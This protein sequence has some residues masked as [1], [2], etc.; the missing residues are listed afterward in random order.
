MPDTAALEHGKRV[1][2][3]IDAFILK[4]LQEEALDP[5]PLADRLMLVRRAYFDLLGLPP[6]AEQVDAFLADTSPDAWKNLVN[7]LLDSKHYGERWARHWLDVARYA[8]SGGFES[9]VA[10]PNSWR[11]RDYV[12]R[13]FN[14]DKPYD[15]FVQEQIAGDEIW[16]DNRDLDPKRVYIMS[17]AK[18]R[19]LE[20]RIG[21]GLYGFGSRVAEST[22]DARRWHHETLTDWVD[23]TAS[24]FMGLTIQCARCHD[25][26]FDPISQED[27]YGMQAIFTSSI[28]VEEPIIT[29]TEVI[30]W[31][32]RYPLIVHVHE[33]R[34]AYKRFRER[35]EGR[36]LTEAEHTEETRL[37][38]RIVDRVMKL[39][40]RNISRP[41][42]PHDPLM[43]IP[44]ATVLGH[45]RREL[46]K[47]VHLLDRGELYQ[48]LQEINPALPSTLAGATGR[49]KEVAGPYGSRKELALWLT[50][51]D[52]PLTARV[53]VNRIWQWH[54][55]QGIVATPS[56][57]GSHGAPPTHPKL[58]DWLATEFVK[59]GWS[60]KEMHRL[61]MSSATYSMTSRFSTHE[62]QRRDPDNH[63]LWRMNRRRLEGEA[64]WDAVHA[65]GGTINLAMGGRPVMPPLAE[66]EIAALRVKDHW[67]VSGD[68][69]QHT[70]R[71]IYI[72]SLRNF[73]FPMFDVFDAPVNAVSCPERDVT[74]VAPQAL[75][76]LNSPTVYRQ[77]RQLAGRAVKESAAGAGVENWVKT[78]WKIA[79]GR[80]IERKEAAE[81]IE[82]VGVV[83]AAQNDVQIQE[84]LENGPESLA[85]LPPRQAAALVKLCLAVY[86][87]NEFAFVH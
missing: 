30:S 52:H 87:L 77:A 80:P 40:D 10:Y 20:A 73:R 46:I 68:P 11:Y 37:R 4:R 78:I 32:D 55:G 44:V 34:I 2:N 26:K 12:V 67:P 58:L 5:A 85:S 33:A 51:P 64:L 66:D 36:K 1:R 50:R 82:L 84:T 48:P 8:D 27:Y 72:L 83:A 75:F 16:P 45:E 14:V 63:L 53:M 49:S 15:T 13:S 86:N 29:P 6:T 22:L 71:G 74:T 79:L 38:D 3:P 7:K 17:E 60:I 21:T 81:A 18:K 76:S 57:F 23:T 59:R 31:Q 62:H 9:D 42:T 28:E 54:F 47:P 24:L 25:H 39:D 56:D 70:R 43:R 35:T 65:T 19:H 61:I 69:A 41:N